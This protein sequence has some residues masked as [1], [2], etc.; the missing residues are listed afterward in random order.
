VKTHD[1]SKNAAIRYESELVH[2]FSQLLSD[3]ADL[4][5]KI[6][7]EVSA[8]G[9][10]PWVELEIDDR[11]LRFKPVYSLKPGIPE[12]ESILASWT[13]SLPPLLIAPELRPWILDFS[14]QLART[15][16]P[17]RA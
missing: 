13:D 6:P 11:A 12:L 7:P 16:L 9:R 15:R 14:A 1:S 17:V 10:L 3:D 8:G 4:H 2:Q 5:W